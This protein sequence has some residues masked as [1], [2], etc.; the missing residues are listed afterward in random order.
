MHIRRVHS[1]HLNET[2]VSKT[3]KCHV[4]PFPGER[5]SSGF[6]APSNT[7][8]KPTSE[9]P[10]AEFGSAEDAKGAAAAA[11]AMQ[12][13]A[14]APTSGATPLSEPTSLLLRLA[15]NDPKPSGPHYLSALAA[16]RSRTVY[17]NSDGD[18]LVGWANSSLRFQQELPEL[19]AHKECSKVCGVAL[20]DPIEAAFYRSDESGEKIVGSAVKAEE[21]CKSSK[22]EKMAAMMGNLTSLPWARVDCSWR[23]AKVSVFA[24]NHIQVTR[25]WLNSEVCTPQVLS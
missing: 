7:D 24:H 22:E 15:C 5:D 6:L 8:N 1:V 21:V 13:V 14:P 10:F 4:V 3:L 17:A 16:F 12:G 9:E 2:R 18:H 25:R 20:E 23:G 19:D 11:S